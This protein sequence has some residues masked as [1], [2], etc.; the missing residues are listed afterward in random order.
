MGE[1]RRSGLG[2][3]KIPP[4][5]GGDPYRPLKA[6]LEQLRAHNA[7]LLKEK[8]ER[9]SQVVIE[10][11]PSVKPSG[12]SGAL[13]ILTKATTWTPGH[14]VISVAFL[15]FVIVQLLGGSE[16]VSK[17]VES[18]SK[19]TELLR[20]IKEEQKLLR[21]DVQLMQRKQLQQGRQ[22]QLVGGLASA[23]NGG[24]PNAIWPA[25]GAYNPPPA[26][27]EHRTPKYTTETPWEE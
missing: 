18:S 3:V 4:A 26:G 7:Q 17:I 12:V 5:R 11:R 2:G 9:D 14:I 20:E 15:L 13:H 1:D 23:L 27:Q 19:Q 24:K 10:T 8:Q 16:R 6:E 25:V 22:I 21:A